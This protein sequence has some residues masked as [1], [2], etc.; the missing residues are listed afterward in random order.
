VCGIKRTWTTFPNHC[1]MCS[2]HACYTM[3]NERLHICLH[4]VFVSSS[5]VSSYVCVSFC[6][7]F[8]WME[9]LCGVVQSRLVV[10]SHGPTNSIL[11]EIVIVLSTGMKLLSIRNSGY[12]GV[13]TTRLGPFSH[14]QD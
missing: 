2:C 6:S 4:S 14:N 3:F 13:W 5:S 10:S 12:S 9:K 8:G 11:C 1:P 7:S